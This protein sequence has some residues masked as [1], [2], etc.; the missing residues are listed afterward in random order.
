MLQMYDGLTRLLNEA[1]VDDRV[2]ITA[3]TGAGDVYSSGNDISG[4][5]QNIVGGD[6]LGKIKENTNRLRYGR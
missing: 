2:V 5:L 3:L 4:A 1:A 6:F